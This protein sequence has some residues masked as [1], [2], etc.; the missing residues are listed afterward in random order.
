MQILGL[1][2]QSN[3]GSFSKLLKGHVNIKLNNKSPIFYN[4]NNQQNVFVETGN[5][6]ILE[7]SN[8]V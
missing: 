3:I 8:Y 1:I 6:A 5:S 4:L 2:Y 7:N